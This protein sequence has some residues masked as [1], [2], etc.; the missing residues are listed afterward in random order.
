[1]PIFQKQ[2]VLFLKL[3]VNLQE[4]FNYTLFMQLNG[5]ASTW[6]YTQRQNTQRAI[7]P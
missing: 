6:Q 5:Q 7:I 2:F 4:N 3:E 1:M